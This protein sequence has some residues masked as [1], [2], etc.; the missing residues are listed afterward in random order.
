MNEHVL[1]R[2]IQTTITMEEMGELIQALG[3]YVRFLSGD[4]TLRKDIYDIRE[5]IVEEVA[6]VELCLEKFKELNYIDQYEI[7]KIKEY[8]ENRLNN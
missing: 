2:T 3:K 6:D 7:N 4:E 8:K 5:M 1:G